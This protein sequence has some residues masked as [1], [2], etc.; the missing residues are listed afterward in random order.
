VKKLALATLLLAALVIGAGSSAAQTTTTTPTPAAT[1]AG[2]SN[3]SQGT[4]FV[5]SDQA[6]LTFS[7]TSLVGWD[8]FYQIFSGGSGSG[9]AITGVR[10]VPVAGIYTGITDNVKYN[11]GVT[12]AAGGTASAK[13]S[14]ARESDPTK[15]D[16]SY[17]L[18][19]AQDGCNVSNVNAPSGVDSGSGST[20][21]TTTSSVNF[22]VSTSIFAPNGGTL[23]PNLQQEAAVVIGP[24]LS[25]RFRSQTPGLI[26]AQCDAFPLAEPGII[27]DNDTITIFWSWFTKTQKQ[28]DD[29]LTNAI[30]T[31]KLNTAD[32]PM[33][34][35][36]EPVLRS[37]NIWVFYTAT[38]G[39]LT[40]GH[41]E[42]GFLHTWANPVNDGYN[43]YGPGTARTRD[44]GICN[45]DVTP[46]PDNQSVTHN[47]MYFPTL[48]PTHN[49]KPLDQ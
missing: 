32:L 36:T 33:T 15:I 47:G 25:D 21:T 38:V 12:V 24:R 29:E 34:T 7:G 5:C 2:P 39:N 19:D 8:V 4:L 41:Y 48:F 1:T 11:S 45:F 6:V 18:T 49:I 10:Q 44:S 37:G 43:D 16:F 40:P 22:G 26:F 46:N 20:A 17:V 30:Y 14:V 9:T 35:R 27:Y 42:V 23:N 13:V 3:D 31:V 28:M